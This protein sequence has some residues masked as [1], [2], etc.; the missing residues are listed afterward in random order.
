MSS[1]DVRVE[2]RR[3]HSSSGQ[4]TKESTSLT[5][6]DRLIA[7]CQA[8][9]DSETLAQQHREGWQQLSTYDAYPVGTHLEA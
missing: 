3:S 2:V 8:L 6:V 1:L 9:S 4:V 5:Y 7:A